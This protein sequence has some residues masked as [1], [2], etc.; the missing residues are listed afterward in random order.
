MEKFWLTEKIPDQVSS[1]VQTE[2]QEAEAIFN[3]FS[4]AFGCCLYVRIVK[5]DGNVVVN[6]L[7]SKSRIAPLSNV[8]TI[9]HLELNGALLLAQL[10]NRVT[11]VL[12]FRFPHCVVLYSDSQI[13]LAWIEN[14]RA[15]DWASDS[16]DSKSPT[17]IVIRVNGNPVYWE[18]IKQKTVSRSSTH[19]ECYA[20]ADAAEEVLYIKGILSDLRDNEEYLCNVKIFEDNSGALALAKNGNF[21]KRSKHIDVALHFV[22]DLVVDD[23]IDIVKTESNNNIADMLTKALGQIK[24][25]EFRLKLNVY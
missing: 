18:T 22:H 16:L 8:L 19:A 17:G 10:A 23:K 20:L 9:P 24:F 5:P 4:K 3:A 15:K 14:G 7:C 11:K 25:K 12:N 13:V 21:T 2:L 1:K 6:L